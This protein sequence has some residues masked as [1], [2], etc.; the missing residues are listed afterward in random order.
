MLLTISRGNSSIGTLQ[1][2]DIN[3]DLVCKR[4]VCV[5]D[6]K[7]YTENFLFQKTD[8]TGRP[9]MSAHPARFSPDDKY[10]RQRVTIKKR[11]GI[12]LTQTPKPV[13]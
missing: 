9:T 3:N 13:M 4:V 2:S 1:K 12:L 7:I 6:A 11:F 5:Q 10:S 8:P